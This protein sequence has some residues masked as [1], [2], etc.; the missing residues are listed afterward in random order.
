MTIAVPDGFWSKYSARVARSILEDLKGRTR[1]T[2]PAFLTVETVRGESDTPIQNIRELLDDLAENGYVRVEQHQPCP[3]CHEDLSS[4]DIERLRCSCGETFQEGELPGAT[5]TY[6]LQGMPSRDVRWAITIHGMNTVGVWQQDFA[7][8]LAKLYGYSIPVGLYKYENVKLAP[9]LSPLRGRHS[10]Q[11]LE[12]FR[13]VRKEMVA[14]GYGDRP[15]VIAHSFGT[16]LLSQVLISDTSDDPICL[17]RVVLTGSIVRP[18][19]NWDSLI[20]QGRVEAILC[21]QASRDLPARVS[22]WF[23]R[24]TGPSCVRGFNDR[25]VVQHVVSSDFGHSDYFIEPHMGA[26]L[27]DQWA[28]FLTRA[29]YSPGASAREVDVLFV[30]W[31]GSRWRLIT[32]TFPYIVLVALA[33]FSVLIVTSAFLGFSSALARWSKIFPLG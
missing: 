15:D 17:G 24:G 9:F 33:A 16:W 20:K 3:Q 18:D 30:P 25:G 32:L 11:L 10:R 1:S 7:W 12:Y 22:H 6:V 23:I 21:H 28:P 8:R 2:K 29:N 19:F 26:V 13:N 5:R 4:E 14:S 27:T 31:K